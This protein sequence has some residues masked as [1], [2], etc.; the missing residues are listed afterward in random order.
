MLRSR[1][2]LLFPHRLRLWDK[3]KP[4]AIAGFA[5]FAEKTSDPHRH[6]NVA[7]LHILVAVFGPHLPGRLR[8]LEL[9]PHFAGFTSGLEEINQVCGIEPDHKRIV[10]VW[11]LDNV[12]GLARVR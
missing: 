1:S 4:A 6:Q 12:F 5:L 9:Q 10:V 7:V 8:V 2:A 3:A 11:R